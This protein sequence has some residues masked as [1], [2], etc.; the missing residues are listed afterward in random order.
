VQRYIEDPL[1]EEF[2][3]GRFKEGDRIIADLDEDKKVVFK[4]KVDEPKKKKEKAM[5]SN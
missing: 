3:M 4:V 1:S 5:A 2:L